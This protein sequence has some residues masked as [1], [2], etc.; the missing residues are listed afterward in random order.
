MT[1]VENKIP[2]VSNLV[3]KTDNDAKISDIK[4]KCFAT[5]DY[6]KFTSQILDAKIKQKELA[7]KSAI[8]GFINNADLDKKKE[9]HEQQKKDEMQNKKI[10]KLQAFDSSYFWSKSHF[11]DDGTQ[12]YLVFNKLFSKSFIWC[13]KRLTMLIIFITEI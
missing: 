9:L 7:D 3:K 4:S 2:D 8:A 5:A 13:L 1:A 12:N 10:I 11:E 6:N